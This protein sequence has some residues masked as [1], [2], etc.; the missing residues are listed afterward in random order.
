MPI[1]PDRR[2]GAVHGLIV[3]TRNRQRRC[4]D[5]TPPTNRSRATLATD[6]PSLESVQALARPLHERVSA[7][8]AS[9]RHGPTEAG[10]GRAPASCRAALRA[11]ASAIAPR[12]SPA[13]RRSSGSHHRSPVFLTT[14]SA[15]STVAS[16]AVLPPD[17]R[18]RF[19]RADRAD[20]GRETLLPSPAT[21][22]SPPE[23]R[24]LRA[25]ARCRRRAP[26]RGSS[27]P[28][29]RTGR[30]RAPCSG[31]ARRRRRR[32]TASASRAN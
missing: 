20:T 9:E 5:T 17:G 7:L 29:R 11:R 23:S 6:S 25:P 12:S 15:S 27:A 2:D 16:A 30:I 22:R 24:P 4:R 31:R 1:G 21:A 19:A 18:L 3:V 14:S 26:S 32:R 10:E 13:S 8:A 28:R